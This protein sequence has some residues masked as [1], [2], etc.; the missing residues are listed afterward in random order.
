VD[1]KVGWGIDEKCLFGV[2]ERDDS[3]DG[4]MRGKGGVSSR[5]KVFAVGLR[6]IKP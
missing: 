3:F 2:G 6:I 1:L 5:R 4:F